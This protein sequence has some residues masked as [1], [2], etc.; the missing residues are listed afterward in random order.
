[1]TGLE[2]SEKIQR[3]QKHGRSGAREEGPDFEPSAQT[4][5]MWMK[6]SPKFHRT[7]IWR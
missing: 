2:S 5:M 1:M 3:F 4:Q 6:Q 7:P